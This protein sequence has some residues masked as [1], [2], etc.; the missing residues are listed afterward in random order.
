V[1]KKPILLIQITDILI[2]DNVTHGLR[3]EISTSLLVQ[4]HVFER[5][6]R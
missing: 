5:V 2:Q 3:R 1:R 4:G 6:E